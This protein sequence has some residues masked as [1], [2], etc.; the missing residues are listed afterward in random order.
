M[1]GDI[2]GNDYGSCQVSGV[3]WL[4][5]GPHVKDMYHARGGRLF[6]LYGVAS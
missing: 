3:F 6:F 1:I 5:A 2:K 4:R